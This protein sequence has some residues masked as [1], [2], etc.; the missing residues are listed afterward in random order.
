MPNIESLSKTTKYQPEFPVAFAN[1]AEARSFCRTFFRWHNSEH[2]HSGIALFTPCDVHHG[3]VEEKSAIRQTA[4][5]AAYTKHPE[6]FVR[7]R[8]KPLQLAAA[9]YI[10]RPVANADERIDAA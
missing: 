6:R 10:N 9:S 8:P 4:L 3:R 1:L 7:G 5:D 2:R